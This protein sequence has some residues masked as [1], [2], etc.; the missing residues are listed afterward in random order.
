MHVVSVV[1][2]LGL[3]QDVW[4]GNFTGDADQMSKEKDSNLEIFQDSEL[5]G[6]KKV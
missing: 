6:L 3:G 2:W 5:R 1:L 4:R